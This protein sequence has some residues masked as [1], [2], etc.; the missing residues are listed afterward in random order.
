MKFTNALLATSA[1]ALSGQLAQATELEVSHWWTSGGEAAAVAELAEAFN[2]TGNT[3]IDGAIAGSGATAIPMMVSRIAGGDPM[4][5]FQFNH[6]RQAEEL[7]EAGL[8]RDIT[9]IAEE[10][11]WYDIVNPPSLLDACTVDGRLYCVPINVQSSQW[12]WL[13]N[14]A[15][16]TA[17]VPMPTSWTE[18]VET[19]PALQEAGLVPLAM[20]QQGWQQSIVF[21]DLLIALVPNEIYLQV[22]DEKDPEVAAGPEMATV[23]EALDDARRLSRS[24]TVQSWNEATN[25]V[26]TGEAGAQI[27]GD[28]AQG[29]FNLAG[30]VP[31]EDYSCLP[32]LGEKDLLLTGGDSFY[33]PVLD[34]PARSEA[35]AE[36]ARTLLEPRAQVAFN[37]RKGSLPVRGDVDLDAAGECMRKGLEI[38][39]AGNSLPD[40]N[41]LLTAD[42]V[43]QLRDLLVEFFANDR[44]TAGDAQERFARI[45][46]SAE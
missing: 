31:G 29:E 26:I 6:G 38:L 21:T 37:L 11:G 22:L 39:A 9:D 13:S 1:L 7:I 32:G 19:A 10:E 42:S 45:I 23:F 3:W 28:W 44:M 15:Y 36:L 18:F 16:E 43:A 46:R 12:M 24:S 40:I 30:K 2:D 27:M 41:I 25:M 35:Q 4:G 34:D 14:E 17:G 20:G 33:F 8:L 5:A